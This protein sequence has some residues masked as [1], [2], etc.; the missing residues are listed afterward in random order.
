MK[1][2]LKIT[3]FRVCAVFYVYYADAL[4][5]STMYYARSSLLI[6]PAYPHEQ[7][8]NA[9]ADANHNPHNPLCFITA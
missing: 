6:Q 7:Q 4:H 9:Y 2:R 1:R 8:E 3:I 5:P